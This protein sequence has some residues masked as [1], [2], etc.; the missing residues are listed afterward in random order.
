[1]PYGFHQQV[2]I[3]SMQNMLAIFVFVRE[4]ISQ[5]QGRLPVMSC[6]RVAAGA[7]YSL[8]HGI[9]ALEKAQK[10]SSRIFRGIGAWNL[11]RVRAICF[12]IS[13]RSV[14]W[15]IESLRVP[16]QSKSSH[17]H[18]RILTSMHLNSQGLRLLWMKYMVYRL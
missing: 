8:Q 18:W 14:E 11:P 3:F 12:A 10:K 16:P 17:E 2:L 1:M 15:S 9:V 5:G 6:V 4:L 13:R 7:L